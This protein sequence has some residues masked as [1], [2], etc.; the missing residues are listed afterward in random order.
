MGIFKRA[1]GII[2]SAVMLTSVFA[3]T[4][5]AASKKDAYKESFNKKTGVLTISG[6][7]AM[8]NYNSFYNAPSYVGKKVKSVVIKNGITK[9]GEECFKGMKSIKKVTIADSVKEIKAAAF[10]GCKNLKSVKLSKNLKTIRTS[11]FA[12]CKGLKSI[13]LPASVKR[14]ESNAFNSTGYYNN[15]KNWK[16]GALYIGKHL[17]DTNKNMPKNFKV[18]KGTI[19]IADMTSS[20]KVKSISIPASVEN[21]DYLSLLYFDNIKSFKVS[22]KNKKFC[23]VDGNLYNKSKTD[24]IMYATG[25]TAESF[26]IPKTVKKAE[27]SCFSYCKGLKSVKISGNLTTISDFMFMGC[28][29]LSKVTIA[30]G[31]KKI[32]DGAF[33]GCTSLKSIVLPDGL[34]TLGLYCFEKCVNLEKITIPKSVEDFD[35]SLENIYIDE[36]GAQIEGK[37]LTIVGYKNSTAEEAAEKIGAVFENII[38]GEIIDYSLIEN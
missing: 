33:N 21:I 15:K 32:D 2:L 28:E 12:Y 29:N 14:V 16:G 18:K 4:A 7:G 34:K 23:S 30:K 5:G 9:I 37:K 11:A 26:T 22:P 25:K 8:P 24:L 17:C 36:N 38:T 27:Y 6:K 31:V 1:T 20:A 19:S 35:L 10:S 3:V 13:K